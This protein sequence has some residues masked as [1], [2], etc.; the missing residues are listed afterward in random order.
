M[1]AKLPVLWSKISVCSSVNNRAGGKNEKASRTFVHHA[2]LLH[3]YTTVT[4][5]RRS[6]G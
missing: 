4:V 3:V 5:I 6:P 1:D 2:D